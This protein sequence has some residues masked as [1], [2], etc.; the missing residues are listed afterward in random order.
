VSKSE[1]TANVH[2]P[3]ARVAKY[4]EAEKMKMIS[5]DVNTIL[6]FIPL[7]SLIFTIYE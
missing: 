5:K 1:E 2:G 4:I 6:L 3:C 7:S